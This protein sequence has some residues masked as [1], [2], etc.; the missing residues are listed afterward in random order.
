MAAYAS[1]T[2]LDQRTAARFGNGGFRLLAGQC[3][4]TNYNAVKVK[5]TFVGEFRT[6]FRVVCDGI[7]TLGYITRWDNAA[8][9]FKCFTAANPGVEVADNTNIGIVNFLAFGV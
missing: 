7:S 3:N 4:I 9:S 5:P 2:A 6:L 8:Q 1:T